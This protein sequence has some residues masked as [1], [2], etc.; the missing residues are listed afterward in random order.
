MCV[1]VQCG[2]GFNVV[3]M[4]MV[5]QMSGELGRRATAMRV[6]VSMSA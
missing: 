3:H 5:M 6:I 1:A 2:V 4:K